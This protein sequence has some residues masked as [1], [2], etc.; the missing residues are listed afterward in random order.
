M[1][2]E[3]DPDLT[4]LEA[5]DVRLMNLYGVSLHDLRVATAPL[6]VLMATEGIPSLTLEVT[7]DGMASIKIPAEVTQ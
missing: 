6:A 3:Q 1:S 2:T 7:T 4:D 5:F